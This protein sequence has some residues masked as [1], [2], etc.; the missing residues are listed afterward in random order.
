MK[1]TRNPL[2]GVPLI[3]SPFF[4][5][6]FDDGQ[7]D[8]DLYNAAVQLNR[9][10]FAVIDFPD[11]DIE[12]VSA[13]IR[14]NLHDRYDWE[15]WRRGEG[16]LRI[17]DAWSFDDDVARLA[18]NAQILEMLSAL[19]GRKAWPFQTLNFPVG[20]QQHYHTDSVHFSSM[21]E[22]FMCGVWVPLEDVGFDQGP[23]IYYPGSHKWP[24]FANEHIGYR[25][26]DSFAT[27]QSV[28]EELWARMVEM[29]GLK[30]VRLKIKVGQALIWSANLLHGGDH[31]TNL[32]K[33]RWS[34]VTHYYFDDCAYYTPMNSDVP[35]GTIDFRRP[36]NIMTGQ[37]SENF[38]LGQQV[39]GDYIAN[40]SPAR[41]K[42]IAFDPASFDAPAY[43]RANP[44]VAAANADPLEHWIHFGRREGRKLKP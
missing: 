6:A 7:T 9:D 30:P 10:G 13:R 41:L 8:P 18:K 16:S 39:R 20:T 42:A 2:P 24:I 35:A 28:Y 14:A 32:E 37:E 5:D 12:A 38:Y 40:T 26:G 34:Q 21:P 31:Q 23:L 44:D 11:P 33:T 27:S 29:T 36:L 15:A 3:E 22:R 25:H 19:Y 4:N 17:Q 43:L 1:N